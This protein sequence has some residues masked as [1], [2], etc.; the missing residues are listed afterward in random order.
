[1][2]LFL[3]KKLA[4]NILKEVNQIIE[5]DINII[6]EKGFILSSTNKK[7]LGTFHEAAY[8]LIE[9]EYEELIV[10]KDN[11][12]RGCLKGVNLP[13]CFS[14]QLIGVIGVTGDPD[15]IIQIARIIQRLTRMIIYE[16]FDNWTR[17]KIEELKLSFINDLIMGNFSSA[18]FKI[19]DSLQTHNLNVD[20]PFTAGIIDFS[21]PTEHIKNK[22]HQTLT[23]ARLELIK[24]YI[25]DK[26]TKDGCLV[27]FNGKFHIIISNFSVDRLE[28]EIIY[29]NKQVKSLYDTSLISTIGDSYSDYIDIP[30]SFNEAKSLFELVDESSGIYKFKDF[31]LKVA[32]DKIPLPYKKSIKKQVFFDCSKEEIQEFT[33]FIIDYYNLNGSLIKLAKKY[34]VHKN[35]I[36]YNI[37]KIKEKTNYDLRQ[38][39]DLTVLYLAATL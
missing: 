21:L 26:L 31:F 9:N 28:R 27:S 36:Q 1:M 22:N 25:I 18:F 39:P 34:Y 29:I 11:Q 8:L 37:R 5:F 19:E 14:G 30:K 10:E 32:L 24:Q 2:V 23:S 38:N 7:R 13:L 15:E 4:D 6:N 12:Y 3:D 20:G 17:N 33:K 35:T 16:I